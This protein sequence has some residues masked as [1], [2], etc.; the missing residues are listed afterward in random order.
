MIRSK[1]TGRGVHF[2]ITSRRTRYVFWET[3][4]ALFLQLT[5]WKKHPPIWKLS[6]SLVSK[7]C[8]FAR[9]GFLPHKIP[10]QLSTPLKISNSKRLVLCL[11][12]LHAWISTVFQSFSGKMYAIASESSSMEI[13]WD[14]FLFK[15]TKRTISILSH[16][17][18]RCPSI[19]SLIQQPYSFPH[20]SIRTSYCK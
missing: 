18:F 2:V 5:L 12:S 8:L 13:F 9:A 11:P 15:P 1:F 16:T 17:S 7:L 20:L 14:C 19:S 4:I 10:S 3:Q 6:N